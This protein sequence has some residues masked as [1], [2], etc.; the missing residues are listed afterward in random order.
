MLRQQH[1]IKKRPTANDA[2][3]KKGWIDQVSH[4]IIQVPKNMIRFFMVGI[5]FSFIYILVLLSDE[6]LTAEF[7]K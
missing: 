3:A 4:F 7:A 1:K 5:A 2:S 6:E